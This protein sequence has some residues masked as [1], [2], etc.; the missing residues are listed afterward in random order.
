[1][2]QTEEKLQ[3]QEENKLRQVVIAAK[4][5]ERAEAVETERVLK[6][7]EIEAT[8]RERIV[9]L[10]QIEKEK[11]VEMERKNI[12]DVIR[13]RVSMERTVVEE[14]EKIKDVEALKGANR[15]KDVALIIANKDAEQRLIE[16]VKDAESKEKSAHHQAQKI[17][18]EANA[19]KEAADREAEARKIIAE[20]KA[21]EEATLGMSEAQV[22][23]A[24][25]DAA[26]RQGFVEA[27]VIEKKAAALRKEGLVEAEIIRE[28]AIADAKGI[29]EKAAAMKQL[30]EAG[31]DFEEFRLKLD[32]EK[33][34][35][36]AQIKMQ[37]IIAQAQAAVLG[38][39]FKS[40]NIEIVGG[41]NMFFENVMRQI[42]RGKGVDKML[43]SSKSLTELK[44]SILAKDGPTANLF[45]R[46]QEIANKYGFTTEDLK[47]VSIAALIAKIQSKVTDDG[48]KGFLD[49]ILNL[50]KGL[51][52]EDKKVM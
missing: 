48:D 35:E 11:A 29:S 30:N 24:K 40:A 16:E 34:V 13:E 12:Q 45:E 52:V 32:K 27:N 33:E 50:A 39:A 44:D 46:I 36:L 4:N 15:E 28:K 38:E 37:E 22:M 18:I 47:N 25:A 9:A 20:A 2:I 8:E 1:R 17:I 41:E 23:H 31:K 26:E 42:S 19:R 51:G 49:N 5:K 3:I 21:K 6:D 10:A 14:Q 7:K 43:D